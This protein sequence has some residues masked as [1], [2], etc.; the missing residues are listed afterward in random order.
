MLSRVQLIVVGV[1]AL[2]GL[3]ANTNAQVNWVPS[4]GSGS[5]FS[6]AGGF[7]DNGYFGNPTLVGDS[8]QFT[9]ANFVANS[10]NGTSDIKA[11]RIQVDLTANPGQRFTMIKITEFG[12]WGITGIGT[13]RAFGSLN[14]IDM[15]NVRPPAITA[16]V[17]GATTPVPLPMP[18]STPGSGLWSGS[19]IIDLTQIVGADWTKLRLVFSNTL[20][21]TSTA[22]SAS[23]IDKKIVGGPSIFVDIFPSPG[24]ASVLAMGGLIAAR[25]RRAI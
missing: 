23:T 18:I 20:Q 14:L 19:A 24:A 6:Y 17:A 10:V 13:V 25:R 15:I 16:L 7:S 9:P 8:F 22:G 2:A 12:G 5:F 3:A 4:F 1:G 11:D 21:A